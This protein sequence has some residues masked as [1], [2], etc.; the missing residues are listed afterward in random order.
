MKTSIRRLDS[1]THNDTAATKLI[2]DNFS[3][4]QQGIEDS[5][6]R[7]GKTPNFMNSDLD[8]NTK[9]IINVGSPISDSDLANKKYVD[10]IVAAEETR[11]S[12]VE[13]VLSGRIDGINNTL[14]AF[15]NI[16]THNTDEF[17]TAAQGVKADTAVQPSDL[18]TVATSGDYDDL[19]NKPDIPV[20]NDST[21]TLTQGGSIMGSF[22]LNQAGDA[23]IVLNGESGGATWGLITGTLSNQTDLQTALAGKQDVISDLATIRSGAS[24]GATAVQPSALNDYAT[25]QYVDDI[26]GDIETLLHNINSGE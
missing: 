15:G 12:G 10:D 24:A 9:R 7:T 20:V 2:N 8:L 18:S 11:A 16:V 25:K 21:I 13:N 22:T 1:L 23:T 26:V 19:S 14:G 3:A 6:S 5:L 17:A 4:L